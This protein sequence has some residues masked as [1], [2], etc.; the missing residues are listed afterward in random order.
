MKYTLLMLLCVVSLFSCN[1]STQPAQTSAV[2]QTVENTQISGDKTVDLEKSTIIWKGHKLIGSHTGDIQLKSGMLTFDNG[3][4]TGGNFVVDMQSIRATELM[5]DDDDEEEE[6][7]EHEG[8]DDGEGHDDR[9]ELAH[10]LKDGD[11]FATNEFP[12]ASFTIKNSENQ[13]NTYKITGDMT[14]KG[15][16]KEVAFDAVLS[17]D[18]LQSNIAVNRTEFGIKYG[19]GT[20]FDLGDNIIKDNFD[21]I[22]TLTMK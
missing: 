21:L 7:H 9:D 2:E 12:E 17:G 4:L 18:Q 22:V 14:I 5:Q 16:T 20:F 13:G 15:I 19:S 10:H 3:A 6:E 11:F 8:D 1:N